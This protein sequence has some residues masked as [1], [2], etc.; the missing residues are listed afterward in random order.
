MLKVNRRVHATDRFTLPRWPS[1]QAHVQF[2]GLLVTLYLYPL[3]ACRELLC[4]GGRRRNHWAAHAEV[5]WGFSWYQ[6]RLRWARM[7]LSETQCNKSADGLQSLPQSTKWEWKNYLE[8]HPQIGTHWKSCTSSRKVSVFVFSCFSIFT[9][10][11]WRIF[12]SGQKKNKTSQSLIMATIDG[13]MK[14]FLFIYFKNWTPCEAISW[15]F[16]AVLMWMC[17]V[18]CAVSSVS[19]IVG[20]L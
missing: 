17:W 9:K 15:F 18:N 19:H 14:S 20:N 3:C 12:C 7:C 2:S 16:Q 10:W 6:N 13:F 1:L 5:L 11:T 8:I 4:A